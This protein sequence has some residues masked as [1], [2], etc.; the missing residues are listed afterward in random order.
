MQPRTAL[1]LRVIPAVASSIVLGAHFLYHGN[2]EAAA[3]AALCPLLLLVRRFW[4]VRA[5]QWL[6]TAGAVI[7]VNTLIVL[8]AERRAAGVPFVRLAIILGA[9]TLV[10]MLA[11]ML[12][13]PLATAAHSE[14]DPT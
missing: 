6:L 3:A 10:T 2:P 12:L 11:A 13:E 9:V 4:A 14:G 1:V 7:W 8:A 5:V